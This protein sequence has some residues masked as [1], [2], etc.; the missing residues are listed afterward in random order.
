MKDVCIY[1]LVYIRIHIMYKY[2]H[3]MIEIRSDDIYI[4]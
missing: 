3:D 4:I 2:T 1:I